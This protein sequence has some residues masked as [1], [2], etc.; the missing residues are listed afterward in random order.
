MNIEIQHKTTGEIKT[1]DEKDLN[2]RHIAQNFVVITSDKD[3]GDA[4]PDDNWRK[5]DIIA[6]LKAK[7]IDFKTS[8][9]KADL[10]A[11]C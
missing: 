6:Y 8:E 9:K 3:D 2:I 10:L 7:D 11:K 1:I 5:A 4:I